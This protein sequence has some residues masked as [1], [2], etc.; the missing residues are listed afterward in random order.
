MQRLEV[1]GAVRPIYGSLGVKWL[2][3]RMAVSPYGTLNV[4]LVSCQQ[5][6]CVLGS[7]T[8]QCA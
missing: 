8:V 1:S 5:S 6:G 2:S 7:H 3:T 4:V